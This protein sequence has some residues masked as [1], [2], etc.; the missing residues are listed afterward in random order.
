MS[1]FVPENMYIEDTNIHTFVNFAEDLD[2]PGDKPVDGMQ[3]LLLSAGFRD[4]P[5]MLHQ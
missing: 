3:N 5:P 2:I 1:V 4:A